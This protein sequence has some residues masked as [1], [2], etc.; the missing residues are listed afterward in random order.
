MVAD[1]LDYVGSAE[2]S[3]YSGVDFYVYDISWFNL[4]AGVAAEDFFYNCH[5]HDVLPVDQPDRRP[6]G[7]SICIGYRYTERSSV[8]YAILSVFR[9]PS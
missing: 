7:K 3:S 6:V 5:S 8:S 4:L 9:F 1:I 2:V